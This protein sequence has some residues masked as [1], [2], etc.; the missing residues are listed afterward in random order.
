MYEGFS[1]AARQVMQKANRLAEKLQHEYVGT[2]HMLAALLEVDGGLALTVLRNLGTDLNQVNDRIAKVTYP[3]PFP[4][5]AGKIPETPRADKVIDHARAVQCQLGHDKTPLDTEH[6]LLGLLFEPENLSA[7]ILTSVGVRYEQVR[8]A[9]LRLRGGMVSYQVPPL[10]EIPLAGLFGRSDDP[11]AMLERC[12]ADKMAVPV[13]VPLDYGSVVV[14][15][16]ISGMSLPD[17]VPSLDVPAVKG[18]VKKVWSDK[19]FVDLVV[20]RGLTDT[21]TRPLTVH[22][23][24]LV[25]MWCVRPG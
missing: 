8:S 15:Y 13:R 1:D 3:G 21:L 9:V 23:S 25:F 10:G 6:L 11:I 17:Y 24:K 22:I 20:D 7:Q 2:E 19:Q 5:G 18:R 14:F 4:V 16:P 12:L